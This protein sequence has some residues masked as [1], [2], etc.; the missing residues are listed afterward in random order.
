[1][2]MFENYVQFVCIF[3]LFLFQKVNIFLRKTPIIRRIH[4]TRFANRILRKIEN[5]VDHLN[6]ETRHLNSTG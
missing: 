3:L 4:K 6:S 5:N 1:M 2:N